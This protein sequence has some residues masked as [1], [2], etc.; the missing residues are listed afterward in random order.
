VG[1]HRP[2][3]LTPRLVLDTGA[4]IALERNDQRAFE[5]LK[6]ASDRGFLV[7]VPTSVVLEALSGSLHPPRLLQVLKAINKELPLEP[8]ISHQVVALR[9]KA[10]R[11]SGRKPISDTDAI[12]VLEALAVPGSIV[13]TDDRQDILAL[14]DAA[15]AKGLVPILTVSPP[16]S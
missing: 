6:V 10:E 12:V 14:I 8:R 9:R 7:V 5:Q 11:D 16:G 3:G 15:G 1:Q 4:L 13:L 2:V